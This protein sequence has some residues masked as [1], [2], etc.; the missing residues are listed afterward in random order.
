MRLYC[1]ADD[2]D[3]GIGDHGER[4][5]IQLW[6]APATDPVH[7]PLSDEDRR[8]RAQYAADM[9]TPVEDYTTE[10]PIH[11]SGESPDASSGAK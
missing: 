11:Y 6:R 4:H 7:P 9:V 3:P 5:L 8:A 1:H 2:P 10:Y